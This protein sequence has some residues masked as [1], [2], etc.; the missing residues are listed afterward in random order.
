M[1]KTVILF[2]DNKKRDLPGDALI[3]H[4]LE[5]SFN[6]RCILEP[7]ESWKACLAAYKPDYLIFNHM[8]A[9]HLRKY[10]HE[11]RDMG[12]MVGVLLNEGIAYHQ[13][14][15]DFLAGKNYSDAHVDHFLAWN[16]PYRNALR[17]H[18]G[19]FKGEINV[20]GI[21][22]FD[23]Y[24]KPWKRIFEHPETSSG[25]AR[26]GQPS[27][28][29]VCTNFG[30]AGLRNAPRQYVDRYFADWA[31]KIPL[32]RNY[33]DFIEVNYRS[34][35]R[36]FDYLH[37]LLDHTDYLIDLKPHP[38][39]ESDPYVEWHRNLPAALRER[40]TLR[41]DELI[42]EVLP[43]CDVHIACETCTTSMEAWLS[44]KPTIELIFEKHP[45]YFHEEFAKTNPLCSAPEKLPD[46]VRDAL[47]HPEQEAYRDIR[48]QHLGKWCDSPSGNSSYKLASVIAKALENRKPPTFRFSVAY[49]RK[50]LKLKIKTAIDMP[51]GSDPRRLLMGMLPGRQMHPLEAKFIR[52]SD[53]REWREKIAAVADSVD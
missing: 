52:P 27:R 14:V 28:I 39:E 44:G 4:H 3:A 36:F 13:E 11:L 16:E 34:R 45:L 23:F 24:F 6:I 8:L 42:W 21:P 10:S 1:D 32:Y 49:R 17:N 31:A 48:K 40:V 50:A 5:R 25:K 43:Q 19:D 20:V 47:I 46:M 51:F 18:L 53:V 15:L 7:L 38:R 30:F 12:V 33:R 9:D 22:R 2:V 26:S 29:L 41:I 37:A 35:D